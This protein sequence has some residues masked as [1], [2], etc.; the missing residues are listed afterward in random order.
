MK[1][2]H[3]SEENLITENEKGFGFCLLDALRASGKSVNGIM[4]W[5]L[6]DDAKHVLESAGYIFHDETKIGV[7]LTEVPGDTPM[8]FIFESRPH[9]YHAEFTDDFGK[10]HTRITNIVAYVTFPKQ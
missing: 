8:I 9:R 5:M 10:V 4:E 3:D 2:M 1:N 7:G 6:Y